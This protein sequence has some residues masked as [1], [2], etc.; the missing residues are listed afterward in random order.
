V[1]HE[2]N[3]G[4]RSCSPKRG[5]PRQIAASGRLNHAPGAGAETASKLPGPGSTKLGQHE[6]GRLVTFRSLARTALSPGASPKPEVLKLWR[7]LVL[8]SSA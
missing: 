7:P 3:M 6:I 8:R 1:R 4:V 2:T 5:R